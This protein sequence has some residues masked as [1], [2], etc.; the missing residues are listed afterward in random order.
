MLCHVLL[1]QL[2]CVRAPRGDKS[3]SQHLV[4]IAI[5]RTPTEVLILILFRQI[6]TETSTTMLQLGQRSSSHGRLL[7]RE[8]CTRHSRERSANTRPPPGV[9]PP[10]VPFRKPPETAWLH[11]FLMRRVPLTRS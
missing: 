3:R 4:V 6:E 7:E 11:F 1:V 9:V 2:L 8:T 5:V 10:T